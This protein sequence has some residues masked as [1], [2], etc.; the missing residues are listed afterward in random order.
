MSDFVSDT[1]SYLKDV[2]RRK[3]ESILIYNENSKKLNLIKEYM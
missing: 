2:I 3:E 1:D